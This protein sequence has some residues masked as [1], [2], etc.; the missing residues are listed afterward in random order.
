MVRT[1]KGKLDAK[2]Q[3]VEKAVASA[4]TGS[5][6]ERTS[7]QQALAAKKSKE[8]EKRARKSVAIP[9]NEESEAES[10]DE[11]VPQ[12]KANMSK[13]KEIA[14]D[15]DREKTPS[16]EELYDHL[17]KG[18]AWTLTRFADLNLLKELGLESDIEAMLGYLKL[19]K[20]LTMTHP[21]YKDVWCQPIF[22]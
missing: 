14:V 9:T 7:R 12:K 10:E 6:T 16:V 8:Q 20:L 4:P 22:T 21:T 13:G 2:K 3:K 5:G 15:R 17:M 18:V 11:Q 1:T 19:P